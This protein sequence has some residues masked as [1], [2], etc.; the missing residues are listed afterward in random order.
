M[1]LG[2][3]KFNTNNRAKPLWKAC[4]ISIILIQK[5]EII[6]NYKKI[7]TT[8]NNYFTDIVPIHIFL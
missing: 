2:L 6:L 7:A 5:K 3:K 1:K 8:L 4:D